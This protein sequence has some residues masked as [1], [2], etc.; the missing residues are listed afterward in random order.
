MSATMAS[1][2]GR[3]QLEKSD[4]RLALNMAK[5]PKEG[6]SHAA[7]EE[8]KYF[9]K[10]THAEVRE[11]TMRGVEFPGDKKVKAAIKR[12]SAMFRHNQTSGCLPCQNGTA[13]NPQKR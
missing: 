2:G 1:Q 8:T 10:K 6:I 11:E 5:M 13:K 4:M 12:H 7:I 9:I 3:V